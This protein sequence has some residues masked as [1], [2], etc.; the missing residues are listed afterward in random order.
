MNK[1]TGKTTSKYPKHPEYYAGVDDNVSPN[2]PN[3][4]FRLIEKP[5]ITRGFIDR[6]SQGEILADAKYLLYENA[7]NDVT[8]FSGKELIYFLQNYLGFT[9]IPW[10]LERCTIIP[11]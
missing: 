10:V 8:E 11:L 4:C 1:K 9:F 3:D 2:N 6:Y 7:V 5:R